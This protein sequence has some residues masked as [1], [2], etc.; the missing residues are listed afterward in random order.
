MSMKPVTFELS[1]EA[2]ATLDEIAENL[3]ENRDCVLREAVAFYLADYAR[4]QT[5][6]DE[7]ERQIDAGEFFTQEQ[8]E[9]RFEAGIRRSEAA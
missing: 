8:M 7:A 1:E 6:V 9:A 4:L 3:G 2:L 5:E